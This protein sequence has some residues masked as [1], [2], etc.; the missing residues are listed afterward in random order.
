[1]LSNNA[2]VLC[3]GERVIGLA[4]ARRLAREWLTYTFDPAS[5]SAEK[6]DAITEYE[7]TSETE[8]ISGGSC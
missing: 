7:G 5:T 3:L 2:Q 4:L 6:V 1:V 8:A